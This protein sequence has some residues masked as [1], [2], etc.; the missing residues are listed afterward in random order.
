MLSYSISELIFKNDSF[1]I[2]QSLFTLWRKQN[3]W[4]DFLMI[5]AQENPCYLAAIV[6]IDGEAFAEELE[7][8]LA[9]LAA[10]LAALISP[11]PAAVQQHMPLVHIVRRGFVLRAG[12][13]IRIRIRIRIESGFNR[14]GGSGSGSR[15][16]KMTHKSREKNF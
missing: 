1:A 6:D 11:P 4:F 2:K 5:L 13:R 8:L 14:V 9:Q 10:L 16:A 12:L 7:Q 15:R 3:F